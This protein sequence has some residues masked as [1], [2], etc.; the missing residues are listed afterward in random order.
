M[1]GLKRGSGGSAPEKFLSIEF[2]VSILFFTPLNGKL[3]IR[4]NGQRQPQYLSRG[5]ANTRG[6]PKR[7]VAYDTSDAR[8]TV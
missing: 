4:L 3:S 1:G 6:A 2:L 5:G 8:V 7:G